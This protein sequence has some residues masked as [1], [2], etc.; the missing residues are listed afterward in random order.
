MINTLDGLLTLKNIYL[1]SNWGVIPFWLLLVFMP[2]HS[3]TN[4]FSNSIIVPLLL[5]VA[6]IFVA[7]GI[8][9]EDNIFE[10]F[11]LYLGLDGLNEVYSN[12][13]FRLVFWLHFLAISLF[14]GAWIARDAHRHMVPKG[15]S[16]PCIIVTYFTGPFGI[17]IYWFVRIFYAK[18]INFNE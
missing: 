10:G 1:F 15:L 2:N 7:K 11:K 18:K 16:A 5:A 9:L 8:M 17:I 4:F 3:I 12:E 13:S 6:Y 14:V